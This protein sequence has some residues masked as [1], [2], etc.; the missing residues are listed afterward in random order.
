MN[1]VAAVQL[2]IIITL[3]IT[4]PHWFI[5]KNTAPKQLLIWLSIGCV[6][7]FPLGIIAYQQLSLE[8]IKAVVAL[9][10]ILVSL[11]TIWQTI[12]VKSKQDHSFHPGKITG[13]GMVS[14]LMASSLAMPGP[15]V[16]IYLSRTTLTKNEIRSIILSFFLFSYGGALLLQTTLVGISNQTWTTAAM[17]TPPALI[18]MVV[19]HLLSNKINP[20][21]FK[22]LVLITL[23]LTGLFMLFNL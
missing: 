10:I 7:G 16:M 8:L 5:L 22:S 1:S 17:L 2:V 3:V 4:I 12:R 19:G 20:K 23:M 11:Q 13:V 21:I 18:G 15:A 14:G 6:I 9:L